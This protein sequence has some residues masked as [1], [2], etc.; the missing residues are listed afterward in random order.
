MQAGLK[1]AG[2]A[3]IVALALVLPVTSPGC[4]SDAPEVDKAA[5][6]SPESLA[7]ELAFRYRDLKPEARK[8]SR[9]AAPRGKPGEREQGRR[10]D[11]EVEQKKGGGAVP[12]KREGAPT[13]DD[14]MDDIGAK[15]DRVPDM[16]RAEVCRRMIEALS[17]DNSLTGDDQ[18]LLAGRLKEMGG[19]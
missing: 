12:K 19:A 13:L 4:G 8:L 16:P 2:A 5:M 18:A 17:K 15:I 9:P 6:Y 3:G 11:E 7:Q 14:V 10:I 1:Q